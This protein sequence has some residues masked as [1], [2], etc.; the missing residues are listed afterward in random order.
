MDTTSIVQAIN[1]FGGIMIGLWV[2]FNFFT[3]IK[4]AE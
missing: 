1:L 4:G 2:G 3:M